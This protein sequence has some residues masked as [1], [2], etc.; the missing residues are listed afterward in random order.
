MPKECEHPH[1]MVRTMAEVF[2]VLGDV[3]RMRIIH[4]LASKM[5]NELCV[6]DLTRKL[7]VTQPAASQH[8]KVLKNI[9]ILEPNKVGNRV[10]YNINVDVLKGYMDTMNDMFRMAFEKCPHYDQETGY[11]ELD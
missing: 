10:Y 5:E 4:M 3:T 9:G 1:A 7:G 2:K 6:S 8:L 11:P